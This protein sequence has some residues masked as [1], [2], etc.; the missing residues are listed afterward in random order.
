MAHLDGSPFTS[1]LD[2]LHP[3]LIRVQLGIPLFHVL[4]RRL[5][6]PMMLGQG[7]VELGCFGGIKVFFER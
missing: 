7:S 1:T 4:A 3:P 6:H 2:L 5:V